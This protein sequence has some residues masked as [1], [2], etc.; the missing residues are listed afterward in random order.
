MTLNV[1]DLFLQQSVDII[2]W[3]KINEQ[4]IFSCN[5]FSV[6]S[7]LLVP[8]VKPDE[9]RESMKSLQSPKRPNSE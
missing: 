6:K 7:F 5:V 9:A 8:A 1:L 2:F 3:K 4:V